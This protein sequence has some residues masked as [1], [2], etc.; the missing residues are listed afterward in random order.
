MKRLR[1]NLKHQQSQINTSPRTRR[2]HL[3]ATCTRDEDAAHW[4]KVLFDPEP[5]PACPFCGGDR[6]A[7]WRITAERDAEQL[8]P[9]RRRGRDG[10]F[11]YDWQVTPLVLRNPKDRVNKSVVDECT[12]CKASVSPW[13]FTFPAYTKWT[14]LACRS[15]GTINAV[16]TGVHRCSG[17]GAMEM[18]IDLTRR[19]PWQNP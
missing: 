19:M 7:H 3:R 12:R 4:L 10:R 18:F 8:R 16:P 13:P 15:C 5:V 1:Q 17:C 14:P 11:L 9:I 2:S 6:W